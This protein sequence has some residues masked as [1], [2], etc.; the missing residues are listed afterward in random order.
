[1]KIKKI[2]IKTKI[3]FSYLEW[4][5]AGKKLPQHELIDGKVEYVINEVP[6]DKEEFFKQFGW[7]VVLIISKGQGIKRW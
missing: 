6:E 3:T 7:K 1:M 4:V 5:A 2:G